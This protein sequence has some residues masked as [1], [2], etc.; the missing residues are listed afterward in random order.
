MR[1][2]D[3]IKC[4]LYKFSNQWK[5]LSQKDLTRE[6]CRQYIPLSYYWRG[7]KT[8]LDMPLQY[9][10]VLKDGFWPMSRVAPL[11]EDQFP[12]IGDICEEFYKDDHFVEEAQD[13][14][15]ES[16]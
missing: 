5:Q 12:E 15:M 10:V 6:F 7:I 13:H 4:S 3:E 16:F 9:N 2:F 11:F 14:P 8:V 1:K